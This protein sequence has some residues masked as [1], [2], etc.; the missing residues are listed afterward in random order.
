MFAKLLYVILVSFHY[1]SLIIIN[2]VGISVCTDDLP[3]LK[4]N[5]FHVTNY[6]D[7]TIFYCGACYR[8]ITTDI[9]PATWRFTGPGCPSVCTTDCRSTSTWP[10]TSRPAVGQ[11]ATAFQK[12]AL[13]FAHWSVR[14]M[15]FSCPLLH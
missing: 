2:H 11:L 9:L 13:Y 1:N 12:N 7:W 10:R 6:N 15:H 4:V 14:V 5:F 8:C 3:L